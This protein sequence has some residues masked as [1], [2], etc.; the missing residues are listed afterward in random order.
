MSR[1]QPIAP[2]HEPFAPDEV[3]R[4]RE[5]ERA[6]RDQ[7]A[8][9]YLERLQAS[10]GT[11]RYRAELIGLVQHIAPRSD[12]TVLDAGCGVGRLAFEVAP[13]VRRL[14]CVDLSP[15]AIDVLRENAAARGIAN[16]EAHVGDLG[17]LPTG[18]GP[19]DTVYCS[20][21]LQH[22]PGRDE[23]LRVLRALRAVLVPG[24]RCLVQVVRWQPRMGPPKEGVRDG[25]FWHYFTRDELC[26]RFR[27]AG[28]EGVA[29][30]GMTVVSSRISRYLPEWC[31][32]LETA[33][34]QVP[35]LAGAGRM[36]VVSGRRP[37][38]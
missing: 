22:V 31:A 13:R 8:R 36:L 24:G 11:F 7:G 2:Q 1:S 35:L 18:L 34:T 17:R 4:L 29:A 27:D 21:V 32:S 38:S 3:E 9:S 15:V 20:E 25:M 28:F 30:R 19:F 14:V 16:I 12:Q 26:A 33:L 5:R 10:R 23:Q 37:V 6:G